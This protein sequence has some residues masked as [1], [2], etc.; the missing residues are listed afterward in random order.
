MSRRYALRG[1]CP[2]H[3]GQF[4]Q[5]ITVSTEYYVSALPSVRA[6]MIHAGC[7][8]HACLGDIVRESDYSTQHMDESCQ[9]QY[10]EAPLAQIAEILRQGD[11][12]LVSYSATGDPSRH[13]LDVIPYRRRSLLIPKWPRSRTKIPYV[14]ISHVWRQG[15]G[16]I[17]GNALPIYQITR[18][19]SLVNC[20]LHPDSSKADNSAPVPFWI[21]TLCCPRNPEYEWAKKLAIRSMKRTYE[22]ADRVLVLDKAL[23]EVSSSSTLVDISARIFVSEWMQRL[24]TLQEAVVARKLSFQLSDGSLSSEKLLDPVSNMEEGPAFH[25]GT[26]F[27]MSFSPFL[28]ELRE[29]LDVDMTLALLGVAHTRKTTNADDEALCLAAMTKVD[30]ASL[31]DV[32]GEERMAAF[33]RL[34]PKAP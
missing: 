5:F 12:P 25:S 16:N 4:G 29:D 33:L 23:T 18:I 8:D 28:S 6:D 27:V 34:L 7:S 10:L 13:S 19:Q 24:W 15:I 9:C 11:I 17:K 2:S 32:R 1:W 30:P 21:D 20:L 14:A 3:V 22:C 26:L 31:L